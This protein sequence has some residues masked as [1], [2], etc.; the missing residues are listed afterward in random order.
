M[1]FSQ[2]LI[3]ILGMLFPLGILAIIFGFEN[4]SEAR[5][6]ATIQRV[7]ESGQ[8]LDEELI[9]GIPGYKKKNPRDDIRSGLITSATGLGITLLGFVALGSVVYG[10]GLLVLSIGV[11]IFAYG[12]YEKRT[13]PSSES[14]D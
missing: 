13:N 1:E 9:S 4:K 7:I 5:F 2:L 14:V 10:A 8:T 12:V 6:H 11:A 3:T